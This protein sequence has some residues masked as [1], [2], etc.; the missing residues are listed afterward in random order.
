[1]ENWSTYR[2]I[3]P[4]LRDL[5]LGCLGAGEQA[6]HLP[7]FKNRRLSSHAMV[8]ISEGRGWMEHAGS[9]HPVQS[10]ALIWVHPGMEHG[11]GPDARGW[12][13]HWVLFSGAGVRAY[14]ELGCFSREQPLV[15]MS[16]P[17]LQLLDSFTALRKC[18]RAEG[19]LADLQASIHTQQLLAIAGRH[20][21]GIRNGSKSEDTLQK[22]GEIAYQPL[23]LPQQ[24]AQL[25]LSESQLRRHVQRAAG[26][27]PKE[28]VLQMRI[29]RSQS[30]L[31]ES[32]HA[33]ERIARL[34]GY[35]DPAY[36]SRL[37]SQRTGMPPSQFRR[38]QGRVGGGSEATGVPAPAS[39]A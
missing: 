16:G 13:E 25:G 32:S 2:P 31:A 37:F 3:A 26:I 38:E 36:F 30:L 19:P 14:E 39:P 21:S 11:Y 17:D 20:S 33:V 6:G 18:L 4:A 1:M 5:G 12:T 29:S 15:H 27:G 7:S 22:L 35:E 10:P 28:F 9:M 24:A 8:Y 23:A 34:V